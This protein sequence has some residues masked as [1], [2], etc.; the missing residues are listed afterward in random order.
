VMRDCDHDLATQHRQFIYTMIIMARIMVQPGLRTTVTSGAT[1]TSSTTAAT[2]LVQQQEG[3]AAAAAG[4]HTLEGP[5][6]CHAMR[7]SAMIGSMPV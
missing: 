1:T 5:P 7:F 3:T 2:R 4:C 6:S